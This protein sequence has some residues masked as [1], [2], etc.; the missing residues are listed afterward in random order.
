M[1]LIEVDA[2]FSMGQLPSRASTYTFTGVLPMSPVQHRVAVA[3]LVPLTVKVAPGSRARALEVRV[4]TVPASTS[5][6]TT[7]TQ[8][9][10]PSHTSMVLPLNNRPAVLFTSPPVVGALPVQFI[11]TNIWSRI[12]EPISTPL[13]SN[14]CT[15]TATT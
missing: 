3:G 4:S 10:S 12:T 7:S 5:V 14:S 9:D 15:S 1:M 2:T 13:A 6:N 11:T 8:N